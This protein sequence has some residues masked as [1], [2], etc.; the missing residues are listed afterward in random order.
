[1]KPLSSELS[2][3]EPKLKK[4]GRLIKRFTAGVA[5]GLAIAAIY[6]GYAQ[7]WHPQSLARSI[8]VSLALA[9]IVGGL[10]IKWGYSIL[11]TV[12]ESINLP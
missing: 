5:V 8:M 10:T 4:V 1:M 7:E 11:Q 12:W 3:S 6:F 9:S 2:S